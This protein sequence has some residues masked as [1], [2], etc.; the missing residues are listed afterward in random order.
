MNTTPI[1]FLAFA[2]VRQDFLPFLKEERI[3]LPEMLQPLVQERLCEVI[4]EPDATA[5]DIFRIFNQYRDRIAIFHFAGHSGDEGLMLE[6]E[7]IVSLL[8][9]GAGLA[10]LFGLQKN[11]QL[12]F[13]NGCSNK[14]QVVQLQQEGVS[15]II[16]TNA[17]INDKAAVSFAKAFYQAIGT[18]SSLDQAFSN[19]EAYL[20]TLTGNNNNNRALLW[21]S[22]PAGDVFPWE[23]FFKNPE[24]S[25]IKGGA[26][27]GEKP[28]IPVFLAYHPN[29]ADFA[30]ELKKHLSILRRLGMIVVTDSSQITIGQDYGKELQRQLLNARIILIFISPDFMFSDET[31]EIEAIATERHRAG[32]AILIPVFCKEVDGIRGENLR[33]PEWFPSFVQ[34]RGVP[35][36]FKKWFIS[37][38]RDKNA[39]FALCARKIRELVEQLLR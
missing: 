9:S 35:D 17:A 33:P 5:E 19:A 20:T 22:Q 11:L 37:Q 15:N 32:T 10:R 34:L 31:Q 16:A 38:W 39:A 23:K 25:I 26:I 27:F 7:G 6:T 12:V 21:K 14:A 24:W 30:D 29:D 1:I 3:S 13:L 8:A 28:L 4:V 18:K 2:N 36:E